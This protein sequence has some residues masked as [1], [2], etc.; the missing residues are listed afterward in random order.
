[1]YEIS[2]SRQKLTFS[3]N[4]PRKLLA[5]GLFFMTLA[6][7]L[8]SQL[9]IKLGPMRTSLL[10][11]ND[12]IRQIAE[13]E[14]LVGRILLAL[15]G[16]AAITIW[17]TWRAFINSWF[18]QYVSSHYPATSPPG[19]LRSPALAIIGG[20]ALL[21]LV[22]VA[23]DR[24]FPGLMIPSIVRED[25]L[26]EYSTAF[27]FLAAA[28][29]SAHLSIKLPEKRRKVAHMVLALGFFLCFGEEISWGQRIFNF[30]TPELVQSFNVQ[31]EVNIHNSFG[32]SADHIFIAGVFVYGAII[33]LLAYRYNF[34]H[35]LFDISGLPLASLGLAIGFLLA[36]LL[37]SWTVYT[38][39]PET[40][41]RMAEAREL[42]S[43]LG[44]LMLMIET[45]W[46]LNQNDVDH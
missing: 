26:I 10:S 12:S 6:G 9:M 34:I 11:E 46:Y 7:I 37:H 33:P 29:L 20:G 38:V 32:Y 45:R 13:Q 3:E 43:S 23:A 44:F 16:V 27:L 19:Q 4:P 5:T 39:F 36:S 17:L 30:D 15:A 40:P 22:W 41:L 42:L 1:M 14:I 21:V 35:R 18:V 24:Y 2:T 28:G 8:S 25:G 31:G